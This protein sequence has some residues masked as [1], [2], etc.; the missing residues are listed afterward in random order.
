MKN[1]LLFTLIIFVPILCIG[2]S[3]RDKELVYK[4]IV[5][6]Q[7]DFNEGSFKNAKSYTTNDW[8]HV[9]PNGGISKGRENVLKEVREV[10]KSFLKNVSMKIESYD[11]RFITPKVAI[12]NV[13][14]QIDNFT[15]PDNK[16]HINERHIK[17]YII[18][19]HHRKWRLIHDHNTIISM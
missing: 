4:V 13:V 8:E 3:A 9:N 2:Q 14:H 7:V 10:H 5:A 19:K 12:A 16:Q 18:V 17:T 15:T 1:R 6:F 11:I